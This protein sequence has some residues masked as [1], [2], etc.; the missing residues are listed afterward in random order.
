MTLILKKKSDLKGP[1]G[2]I[3]QPSFKADKQ[4][5]TI[6]SMVKVKLLGKSK[7]DMPK[8]PISKSI[9]SVKLAEE[10]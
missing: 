7:V 10:K 5:N 8:S 4:Q 6:S 3:D 9:I 1:S 2:P